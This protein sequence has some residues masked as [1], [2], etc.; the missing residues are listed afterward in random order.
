M[1]LL[2]LILLLAPVVFVVG[3]WLMLRRLATET[4][5]VRMARATVPTR[6]VRLSHRRS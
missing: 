5:Q 3:S 4:P 2:P 6:P 1:N